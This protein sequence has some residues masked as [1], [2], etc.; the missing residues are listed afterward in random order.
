MGG[1]EE[2]ANEDD[3]HYDTRSSNKYII[4]RHNDT[5]TIAHFR[6]AGLSP[7]RVATVRNSWN[8][9]SNSDEGMDQVSLVGFRGDIVVTLAGVRVPSLHYLSTASTNPASR[10]YRFARNLSG[11]YQSC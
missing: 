11:S 9:S 6:C 4:R 7:K 10:V 8:S 3:S 2:K 1:E 5:F